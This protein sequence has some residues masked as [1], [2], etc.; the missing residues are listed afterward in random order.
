M[1]PRVTAIGSFLVAT[2]GGFR[3]ARLQGKTSGYLREPWVLF[4]AQAALVTAVCLPA[5][6]HSGEHQFLLVA[7]LCFALGLQ[8][9][10]VT[11]AG[12]VSV[13]ATF[14]SGDLTSLTKL[15]SQKR[16]ETPTDSAEQG[17]GHPASSKGTLLLSVALSFVVG[18]Y[19]ASLL[20]E[21]LGSLIPLTLIVPL[22]IAAV[23]SIAK[24]A[25]LKPDTTP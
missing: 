13:H 11:A 5:V 1:I 21:K 16:T 10:A 24:E 4:L 19:C 2:A 7:G 18:A 14:I 23:L 3:I 6:R 17:A 12:K 20:I 22:G 25:Q 15:L 8:N 9:G